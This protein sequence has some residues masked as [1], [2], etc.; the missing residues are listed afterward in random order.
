MGCEL[1][2]KC[3]RKEGTKARQVTIFN[4]E[5]GSH[6]VN[7]TTRMKKRIDTDYGWSEYSKCMGTVEPV[8]G[9]LA[10]KLNEIAL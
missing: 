10:G 4:K 5:M 3:L 1:R 9:H 8:F 6:G 2:A 7:F